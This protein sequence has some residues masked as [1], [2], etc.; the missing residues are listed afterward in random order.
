VCK[1][2]GHS[3]GQLPPAATPAGAELVLVCPGSIPI[4]TSGKS[5]EPSVHSC[6]DTM[7]SSVWMPSGAIAIRFGDSIFGDPVFR[8]PDEMRTGCG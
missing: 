8:A 1:Q 2:P 4:T 7:S 6:I 5:D 3:A